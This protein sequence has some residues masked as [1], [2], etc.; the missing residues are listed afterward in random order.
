MKTL[1]RPILE[2]IARKAGGERDH[3][4]DWQHVGCP[5]CLDNRHL[6]IDP[7]WVAVGHIPMDVDAASYYQPRLNSELVYIRCDCNG[8]QTGDKDKAKPAKRFQDWFGERI[9]SHWYGRRLIELRHALQR[10]LSEG[11]QPASDGHMHQSEAWEALGYDDIPDPPEHTLEE[12][13]S[14]LPP[15]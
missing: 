15:F 9:G 8:D 14:E 13:D 7:S 4:R 11:Y 2:A 1:T 5:Y 3:G 6:A 12:Y 10:K